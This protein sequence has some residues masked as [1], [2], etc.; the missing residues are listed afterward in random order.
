[1]SVPCP[2]GVFVW[3]EFFGRLHPLVLHL[4]I[5]LFAGVVV[6]EVVAWRSPAAA[7]GRRV[8]TIVFGLSAVFAAATGWLLGAGESYSGA[9]LDEHRRLGIATGSAGALLGFLEWTGSSSLRLHRLRRAVLIGCGALITSTGHH[10]GMI[11]HGQRFLS[12]TAPSWLAPFVGPGTY[13][14]PARTHIAVDVP[15]NPA[16]AGAATPSTAAEGVDLAGLI[17][18]SERLCIEC[19]CHA[20]SKADLRL[21]LVDGWLAGSDVEDPRSSE[22]LYRVMLPPGDPDAM[23]PKGERLDGGSI[24]ALE[25]WMRSGADPEPIAEALST[26]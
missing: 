13:E 9:L 8:L 7:P 18:A 20:K 4:P 14:A 12:E 22:L 19:H 11:T 2:F 24:A 1:M 26:R 15:P 6:M 25:T 3:Q 17:A 16:I 5:G 21:D 10:G 23:P